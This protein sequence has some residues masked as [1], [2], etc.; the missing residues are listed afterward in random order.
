[1]YVAVAAVAAGRAGAALPGGGDGELL[2]EWGEALRVAL[3]AA[4]VDPEL[5]LNW[6]GG[7]RGYLEPWDRGPDQ[8][9]IPLADSETRGLVARVGARVAGVRLGQ[10]SVIALSPHTPISAAAS[11]STAAVAAATV[12]PAT[13]ATAATAQGTLAWGNAHYGNPAG[14]GG[15]VGD[16]EA[17]G[18]AGGEMRVR[19]GGSQAGAAVL[20]T[21]AEAAADVDA[22]LVRAEGGPAAAAVLRPGPRVGWGHEEECAG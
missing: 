9:P 1:V 11:P 6:T 8:Q 10:G 19:G 3:V 5:D 15:G 12:A 22:A 13:T 7:M 20:P 14:V 2:A 18:G 16:A 17:G 4:D 21:W